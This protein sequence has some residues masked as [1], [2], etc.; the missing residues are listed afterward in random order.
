MTHF[1]QKSLL[2]SYFEENDSDSFTHVFKDEEYTISRENYSSLD[3]GLLQSVAT[4]LAKE[5]NSKMQMGMAGG[6]PGNEPGEPGDEP[7]EGESSIGGEGFDTKNNSLITD[8]ALIRQE[9]LRLSYTEQIVEDRLDMPRV[10]RKLLSE[11]HLALYEK[12]KVIDVKQELYLFVDRAV[13]YNAEDKGFHNTLIQE[14][15][16]IKGIH[17]HYGQMLRLNDSHDSASYYLNLVQKLVPR[18]KTIL[19]ISQ[20]C[21]NAFGEAPAGYNFHFATHFKKGCNCGCNTIRRHEQ[22]KN[23]KHIHY[24]IVTPKDLKSIVLQ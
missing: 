17:V 23:V 18:G 10:F 13:S 8:A 15:L 9:L 5:R 3:K 19:A 24:G 21:G 6:E 11:P 16:K 2:E 1:R 12:K 7:A 22:M 20:G 14:A 4:R